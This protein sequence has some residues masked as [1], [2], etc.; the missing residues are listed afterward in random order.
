MNDTLI[1][2]IVIALFIGLVLAPII[3]KFIKSF[4]LGAKIPFMRC[5]FMS[6][7]KTLKDDVIKAVALSQK[8][9]YDIGIDTL[10]AHFLAEGSPLKCIEAME[11]AKQKGIVLNF[12]LVSGANLA[13]KDLF[14]AIEKTNE[15]LNLNFSKNRIQNQK[16]GNISFEFKG[17][18]KVSFASVC[19]GIDDKDKLIEEAREKV[20]KYLQII[21]STNSSEIN[22]IVL[23]VV[24]DIKYWESKGLEVI[25]QELKIK[26]LI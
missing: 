18:Y 9:N 24:L 8:L 3:L 11:Y 23:E 20:I 16:L 6:M 2:L 10:E 22:K 7:R 26:K 14:S 19:F 15:I 1:V 5:V 25:N 12:Q 4:L 13:G 21:E 17:E